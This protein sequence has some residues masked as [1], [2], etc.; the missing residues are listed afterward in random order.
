MGP[1]IVSLQGVD[2]EAGIEAGPEPDADGDAEAEAGVVD[3][4]TGEVTVLPNS[5][6]QVVS[7]RLVAADVVLCCSGVEDDD[8]KPVV[9]PSTELV[10]EADSVPDG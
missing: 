5:S 10:E 1:D 6:V 4:C 2:A 7:I 8:G 9:M 3:P